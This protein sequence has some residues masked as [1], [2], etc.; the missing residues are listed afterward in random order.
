MPDG[1][2]R[3]RGD[4]VDGP[5]PCPWT[6]CRYHLAEPRRRLAGMVETCALDVAEKGGLTLDEVGALLG[7]T[8][9]RARQIEAQAREKLRDLDRVQ[10]LMNLRFGE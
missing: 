4:C 10:E 9:E 3:T 2:P 6:D 5:R 7:V 8:R 1:R